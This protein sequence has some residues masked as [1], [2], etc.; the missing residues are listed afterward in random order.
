MVLRLIVSVILS[1]LL[2]S[3]VF[4]GFPQQVNQLT[5]TKGETYIVDILPGG[6]TK[7]TSAPVVTNKKNFHQADHAASSAHDGGGLGIGTG[8][9][10][11]A[12]EGAGV[13]TDWMIEKPLYSEESRR[14]EEEGKVEV[15][16]A[17]RSDTGCV[18]TIKKSSGFKRL[19]QSVLKSVQK[20]KSSKDEIRELSFVFRL[21]E[22]L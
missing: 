3:I 8:L 13:Q 19:D 22:G 21:S 10:I 14:N 20:I 6:Q 7:V 5:I 2:H 1:L 12:G 17:C 18:G 9:G 11:G 4:Y 15:V 16:V